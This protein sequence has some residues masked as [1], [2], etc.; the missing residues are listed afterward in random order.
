MRTISDFLTGCVELAA[1][2]GQTEQFINLLHRQGIRPHNLIRTNQGELL[3]T[4]RKKDFRR[5]RSP[6]FKTGTRIKILR[7]WGLYRLMRPVRRRFGLVAG[8]LLFAGI[9]LWCS[10]YIWRVEVCGNETL[11]KTQLLEDLQPLGFYP[12]CRRNIDVGAI[13]NRYL[14]GNQR[15]SWISINVKG[16]TAYIEVKEKDLTPKVITDSTPTHIYAA[17]DGVIL[18]ITDFSGTRLVEKGTAVQAGDL[19]I[20][21]ERVDEYGETWRVRSIGSVIA[22]T[23]RTAR[24]N[25]PMKEKIRQKTG[26]KKRF[27]TFFLGKFKI[28]LY[29]REKISYNDYDIVSEEKSLH[30][31]SFALPISWN[32]KTFWE[33]DEKVMERSEK[34]AEEQ[35]QYQLAAFEMDRL[36]GLKITNRTMQFQKEGE[37]LVLEAVFTCEED[38][39]FE[40]KIED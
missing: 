20:S 30:L 7:K 5:L 9:L 22:R 28:P 38:I 19:L 16:T 35:A 6:A 18:S 4:L 15:L 39:G 36:A 27:F 23:Y 11:T 14:I 32:K 24:I 26:R 3:F 25:V 1:S 12:G 34:Q 8:L 17:R 37:S 13:E 2:G 40:R 21:G 29:F 10:R 33:I 31:G